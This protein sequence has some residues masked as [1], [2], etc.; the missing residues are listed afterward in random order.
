[1]RGKASTKLFAVQ[2]FGFLRCRLADGD[3]CNRVCAARDLLR[4]LT[5]NQAALDRQLPVIVDHDE[6]TGPLHIVGVECFEP[7]T[8]QVDRTTRG[9]GGVLKL[10]L[11]ILV[12]LA[13]H[14]VICIQ[15][16]ACSVTLHDQRIELSLLLGRRFARH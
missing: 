12:R 10:L 9:V 7:L 8:I 4:V 6:R 5:A 3:T 1:M 15:C 11:F 13:V 2:R 14:V 16:V